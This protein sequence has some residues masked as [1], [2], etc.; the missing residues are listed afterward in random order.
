MQNIRKQNLL[1][2]GMLMLL[3][4]LAIAAS[5]FTPGS[6]PTGWVSRPVVTLFDVSGG[7]TPS[8]QTIDLSGAPTEYWLVPG[9]DMI[10]YQTSKNEAVYPIHDPYLQLLYLF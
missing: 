5:I 3:T 9:H 7:T 6:Q 8:L 1:I 10:N 4:N 2:G